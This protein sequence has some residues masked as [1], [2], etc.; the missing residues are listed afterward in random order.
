MKNDFQKVFGKPLDQFLNES[1]WEE[2]SQ[3]SSRRAPSARSMAKVKDLERQFLGKH[4][5][6]NPP[7]KKLNAS[8]STHMSPLKPKAMQDSTMRS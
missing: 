6:G 4:G 3:Q 7:N 5:L 8:N 2:K 1:E